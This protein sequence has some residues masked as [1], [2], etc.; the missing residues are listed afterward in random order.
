[1][2]NTEEF[3]DL[4]SFGSSQKVV[5]FVEDAD[6]T[7]TLRAVLQGLPGEL[8]L[9]RGGIRQAIKYFEKERPPRAVIVDISGVDNPQSALDD[10]ARLCPPDVLVFVIGDV[11]DIAFYRLLVDDVGVTEYLPKPLTRDTVQRQLLQRL[12][13][14][15]NDPAAPRGGHVI[16]VCGARGGVG[17]TTIAANLAIELASVSKGH[18]ALLDLHLQGG[19]AALM[20]SATPGAGLRMV[21]EDPDRADGLFLERTAIALEPR[22]QLIAA[23]EP[24]QAAPTATAE[25]VSRLVGLLQRKFNF[26]VIDMPMPVPPPLLPAL[27]AARRVVVVMA[28]DVG[29]L[30]DAHA[31]RGWMDGAAGQH[32]TV[33]VLNRADL[34]GGLAPGL[35]EKGLGGKPDVTIP[36][37]GRRMIEA[38]NLGVPAVRRVP[39]LRRHLAGLVREIGGL[40]PAADSG[41]WLSRMLRG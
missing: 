16:A 41:S 11:T 39:A 13:R 10:L 32:R 2:A 26:V 31:L 9:R 17:A 38:V 5:A 23:Q 3:A 22:L 21:L 7:E 30:R 27:A 28:P 8:D 19:T 36:D 12:T 35:I 6:S 40:A 24:L 25:G 18:V 1:M 33:T 14:G 34:A 4:S 20:F 29:S 37:L 15:G